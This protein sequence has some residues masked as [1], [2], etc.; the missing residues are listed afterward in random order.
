MKCMKI[1]SIIWGRWQFVL[2]IVGGPAC[3]LWRNSVGCL[4]LLWKDPSRWSS[5]LYMGGKGVLFYNLKE[6]VLLLS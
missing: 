5:K 2:T 3:R 1:S 4:S 6:T